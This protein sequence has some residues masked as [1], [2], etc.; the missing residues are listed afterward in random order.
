MVEKKAIKIG[1][2]KK[3]LV[4]GKDDFSDESDE[5]KNLNFLF[6]TLENQTKD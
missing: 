3:I 1:K 6:N 2:T 4:L 5:V